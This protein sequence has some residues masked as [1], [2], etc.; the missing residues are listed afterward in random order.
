MLKFARACG[1]HRGAA[2]ARCWNLLI[3]IIRAIY[4]ISANNI[5][6]SGEIHVQASYKNRVFDRCACPGQ[7]L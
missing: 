2:P 7:W 1:Y 5:M 3:M 6:T 4:G